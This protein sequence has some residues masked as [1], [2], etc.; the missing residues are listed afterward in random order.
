M[1]VVFD[2]SGIGSRASLLPSD[3]EG[4]QSFAI[5]K[6]LYLEIQNNAFVLKELTLTTRNGITYVE[7]ITTLTRLPQTM[8]PVYEG[9]HGDIVLAIKWFGMSLEYA[10]HIRK[11]GVHE[12]SFCLGTPVTPLCDP[13]RLSHGTIAQM[14][15]ILP[16]DSLVMR[17]QLF[18]AASVFVSRPYLGFTY[19]YYLDGLMDF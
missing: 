19:S 17:A 5:D 12:Y 15:H 16:Q 7:R 6:D 8:Q 9:R 3:I 2:E 13:V 14:E 1:F 10:P 11:V 18:K 4:E